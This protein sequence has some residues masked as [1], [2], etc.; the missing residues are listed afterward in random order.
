MFCFYP[1]LQVAKEGPEAVSIKDILL[2]MRTYRMGLIQV[3]IWRVVIEKA[4]AFFSWP[5]VIVSLVVS[6]KV[7]G[8][9]RLE[10]FK[11]V[12][13]QYQRYMSGNG[14]KKLAFHLS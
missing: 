11:R 13:L 1:F 7:V 12:K 9:Y 14:K 2:E 6:V 4:E 8:P 5:F 3:K 10:S